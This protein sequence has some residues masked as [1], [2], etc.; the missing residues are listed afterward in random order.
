MIKSFTIFGERNSGT[1]YLKKILEYNLKIPFT[2]KFGSKHWF[3]KNLKPR[4]I[5][6]TTTD[7]E[8]IDDLKN[9]DNT[10]FIFI[11][12][13]PFDW[14]CSMFKKPHHI[15]SCKDN[16]Y[17]FLTQKHISYEKYIPKEHRNGPTKWQENKDNFYFIEEAENLII[18]RN[19]KN[20][21]FS[22]LENYVKNFYLIKQENLKN[23]IKR[24][25]NKFNLKLK[26]NEFKFIN[27][28]KPS[29]YSI[30]S[31]SKEFII[32]NLNNRIDDQY[33]NFLS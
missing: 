15:H 31:K 27:Y 4:G 8:C 28:K 12:R 21:H 17:E 22:N 14:C 16:L 11:V 20:K 10:L 3:I 23:D 25:V 18:L 1:T 13:N 5:S 7:T 9:S 2:K 24:L 33:I 30:D 6:N 29:K 19:L 26:Y 32:K